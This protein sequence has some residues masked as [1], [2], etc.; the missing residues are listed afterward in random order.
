MALTCTTHITQGPD[1]QKQAPRKPFL[2]HTQSGEKKKKKS[3]QLFGSWVI[4]LHL[5]GGKYT[6][7]SNLG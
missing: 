7:Y 1:A 6:T 5:K 3:T 2:S 4:S